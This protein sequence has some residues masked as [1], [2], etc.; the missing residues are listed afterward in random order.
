MGLFSTLRIRKKVQSARDHLATLENNRL[1]AESELTILKTQMA[2]CKAWLPS[3]PL[4][5]V[6]AEIDAE[7][8]L[9]PG[10][11]SA[12]ATADGFA[13]DIAKLKERAMEGDAGAQAQLGLA[14]RDGKGVAQDLKRAKDC[15]RAAA[16][17][18]ALNRLLEQDEP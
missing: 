10:M 3:I 2:S 7:L 16:A 4:L 1:G 9:S 6:H 5:R 13:D 8:G 15:F 18:A 17:R 11:D 14:Y 12:V